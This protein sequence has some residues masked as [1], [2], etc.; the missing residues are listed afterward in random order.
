MTSGVIGAL[1]GGLVGSQVGKGGALTTV[2]AAAIGAVGAH[3][4]E[5]TYDK[6][7]QK[8]RRERR[9]ERE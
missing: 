5:K 8:V 1:A 6:H 7:R 2:V 9:D 4:A 3:Q